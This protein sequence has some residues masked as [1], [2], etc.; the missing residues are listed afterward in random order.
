MFLFTQSQLCHIFQRDKCTLGNILLRD[1]CYLRALEHLTF[2]WHLQSIPI[3]FLVSPSCFCVIASKLFL[4]GG[5]QNS[6]NKALNGS[7]FCLNLRNAYLKGW[8]WRNPMALSVKWFHQLSLNSSW[9]AEEKW[10]QWCQWDLAAQWILE[11]WFGASLSSL[12][13]SCLS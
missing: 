10:I 5:Q 1:H 4:G 3:T 2:I 7:I 9:P 12:Y 13:S 8:K 11:E 6:L